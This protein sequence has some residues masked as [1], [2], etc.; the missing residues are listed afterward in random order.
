MKTDTISPETA[1]TNPD[2]FQTGQVLTIVG[3]HFTHDTYSAFLAPLLPLIQERLST[4][5]ALTGSL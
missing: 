3:G 5:Y 2:E 1:V 4:S